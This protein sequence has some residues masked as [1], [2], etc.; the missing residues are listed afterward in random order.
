MFI[1]NFKKEKFLHLEPIKNDDRRWFC[2]LTR[3]EWGSEIIISR[4][5]MHYA[6]TLEGFITFEKKNRV[7]VITYKIINNECEIVSLNSLKENRGVG[8]F[9]LDNIER[10]AHSKGC[11]RVWL[12]STNDNTK[13]LRFFQ[14]KGFKIRQIY[15]DI[16]KEYRIL[17]PE[18]PLIGE[19]GIE[20]RD[21][22]E[23]EK[24]F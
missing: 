7:G 8:S 16:M 21:E 24:I 1:I 20:I 6:K 23:L 13:A 17:K 11:T 3:N 4:G 12:V 15:P 18:L 9:L 19:N 22:I 5:K 2:E 10:F 14:K